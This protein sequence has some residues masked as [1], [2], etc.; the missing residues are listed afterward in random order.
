MFNKSTTVR[1][2]VPPAASCFIKENH[3]LDTHHFHSFL[4]SFPDDNEIKINGVQFFLI[5]GFPSFFIKSTRSNFRVQFLD[6]ITGL[7]TTPFRP[8]TDSTPL[9]SQTEDPT[10]VPRTPALSSCHSIHGGLKLLSSN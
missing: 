1:I 5:K 8:F 9:A 2:R 10:S 4:L 7:I 3:V 6:P